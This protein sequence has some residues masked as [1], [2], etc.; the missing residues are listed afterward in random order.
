MPNITLESVNGISNVTL[1]TK[2]E[3]LYTYAK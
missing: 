3:V 1:T 2:R